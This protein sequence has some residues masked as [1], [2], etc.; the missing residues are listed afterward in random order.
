MSGFITRVSIGCGAAIRRGRFRADAVFGPTPCKRRRD[1]ATPRFRSSATPPPAFPPGCFSSL[2]PLNPLQ[3]LFFDFTAF[4]WVLLSF[5]GLY[6]V[7]LGFTGFYWVLLG[8]AGFYWVLIC[9]IRFYWVLLGFSRF[10]WVFTGFYWVLLGFTVVLLVF[11]PGRTRFYW[12][13][14]VFAGFF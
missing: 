14:L 3:T 9:F 13:L 8:F 10:Y 7:L 1:V 4:Y 6:W 5:T 2:R 11:Q 12:V